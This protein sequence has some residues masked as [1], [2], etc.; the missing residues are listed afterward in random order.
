[1]YL[2]LLEVVFLIY[3]HTWTNQVQRQ[4]GMRFTF[5][6]THLLLSHCELNKPSQD[7]PDWA[8][9]WSRCH[10]IEAPERSVPF[11]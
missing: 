11:Y 5:G 6:P 9:C 2:I 3:G 4:T 7:G 10:V 1:M 8:V